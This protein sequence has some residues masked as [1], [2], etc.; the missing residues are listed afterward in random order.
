MTEKKYN[1]ETEQMEE[2]TPD[3]GFRN[4][5]EEFYSRIGKKFSVSWDTSQR[6]A[7]PKIKE[8]ELPSD[9]SM[10]EVETVLNDMK[11]EG[12]F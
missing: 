10:T 6:P 11:A 12:W 9:V 3:K 8:E 7:V 2:I 5:V 4:L 1:P